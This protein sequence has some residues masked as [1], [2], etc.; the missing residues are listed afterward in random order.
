MKNL[1]KYLFSLLVVVVMLCI[2]P[3]AKNVL[4]FD[5]DLLSV[6]ANAAYY[7]GVCGE[8]A[9]WDL[10]TSTGVLTIYGSGIM[11]NYSAYNE[12]P[13]YSV[14]K[15][16]KS[17]VIED[18]ITSIGNS[19]F[20]FIWNLSEVTIADS[21]TIIGEDA[22]AV[23]NIKH[24]EIPDG[25]K[26]ISKFAFST[27]SELEDV[28]IP[29]SVIEIGA[30]AFGGCKNLTSVILPNRL[31]KI[32]TMTFSGCSNLA[33]ITIPVSVELISTN[34]FKECYNLQDFYYL[35]NY[36]E[37]NEIK[38][39]SGND[40]LI[41]ATLHCHEHTNKTTTTKATTS[42][43]GKKV[44][45]CTTCKKTVST[46][47]IPKIST[48][49]L[50]TTKYTYDGKAKTPS[51]TVKDSSG[52]TLKKG[53]DYNVA[54]S[55]NKAIGKATAKVTFKGNY[56]GSKSLTF[57]ILPSKVANLKATQTTTSVKLTWSKVAG[58][59]GY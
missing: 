4:P 50:S 33:S 41:E 43:A 24:L 57:N 32:D 39:Y 6:E 58:A 37:L 51:V 14:N 12:T 11:T 36:D 45:T 23:T 27:C 16:I 59:T 40:C 54:Y 56:S 7:S 9:E 21:V 25:V 30:V 17:V 48:V 5:I 22:F 10:D 3:V 31:K 19:A 42:K 38:I 49:K 26:Y 29:N 47:A 2:T 46:V 55:T 52:K 13:W 8:N 20:K 18:G 44:T 35:G 1:K 34:A 28:S 53:T 15:Y